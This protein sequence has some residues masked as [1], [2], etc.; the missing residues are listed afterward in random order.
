MQSA[1]VPH[2]EQNASG[3]IHRS[4][5]RDLVGLTAL[6]GCYTLFETFV[7]AVRRYPGSPCLGERVKSSI[8][9]TMNSSSSSS[10]SGSGGRFVFESFLDIAAKV[11]KLGAG[12]EYMDCFKSQYDGGKG[13][14]SGGDDMRNIK[15]VGLYMKNCKEWIVA[16]N[17]CYTRSAATV[18]LY[19]T[20]GADILQYIIN[21]TKLSC[22]ICS[23]QEVEKVK[24]SITECPSL[25]VVVVVIAS[26]SSLPSPYSSPDS[27][28]SS[29][30]SSPDSYISS[31][32]REHPTVKFVTFED[33]L[34]L[35]QAFPSLSVAPSP[36]HLAT[37][38]Y[39]SG[40]TGIPKG[41][42]LSHMN[43]VSVAASG[44]KSTITV[45]NGDF[46]LSFLPLAH[47]FERIVVNGLLSQGAAIG[48]YSGDVNNLVDDLKA[49]KPT[50]LCAVPRLLTRIHD[51]VM[52]A[53]NTAE[54]SKGYLLRS[55][56]QRRMSEV[57]TLGPHAPLSYYSALLDRL[58]MR[59]IREGLG[60][61]RVRIMVSGGAPLPV[62][63]MQFFNALMAPRCACFEGY[64][65]TETAGCTTITPSFENVARRHGLLIIGG[66]VGIPLPN[67]DVKLVDVPEMGYFH[68]DCFHS[69]SNSGGG[70][71]ESA[72]HRVPCRGRGEI[73]VRGPGVFVGYFNNPDATKECLTPDGWLRSGDV[74]MFTVDGRLVIIDRIKNL[75]KLSQGEYV[76][77]EKVESVLSQCGLVSQLCV[78]GDSNQNKL[79]AVVVPDTDSVL[80]WAARVTDKQGGGS[81]VGGKDKDKDKD[82]W[83]LTG[84]DVSRAAL[85]RALLEDFESLSKK[86]NLMK[87]EYVYGIILVDITVPENV[88]CVETGMLT[89]TMKLK[90]NL[91]RDKYIDEINQV[92]K[93]IALK[94]KGG[95]S[96]TR[97]LLNDR[98]SKHSRL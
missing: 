67:C 4:I 8:N 71:D 17:A 49:L 52:K 42:M 54:G 89:P 33:V 31:L 78:Y 2:S 46:Y 36:Q 62:E 24:N 87:F 38:C 82:R 47:I 61:D 1:I 25:K 55:A 44:V 91:V 90:R 85:I 86:A 20:L 56:F 28:I 58:V 39:T 50:V 9:A 83:V 3:A 34:R 27:Y 75:L 16:E 21:E 32:N 30:Y 97:S 63:S 57:R 96:S 19:D 48:F 98:S 68:S 43:M 76:A 15:L 84:K 72:A 64:G 40:T 41:A 70:G 73:W 13:S 45:A 29:P 10:S 95:E 5:R 35:G 81:G 18:P 79:V 66:N 14:S 12:L 23:N 60:M 69:S 65:Q 51:K 59:P 53:V 88:W 7:A 22:V 37:L 80:S 93:Q 11:T 94:E 6:D 74:G 92:Y 26:S 77:V